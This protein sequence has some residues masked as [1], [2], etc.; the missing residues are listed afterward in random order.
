VSHELSVRI[1]L[2]GGAPA[3]LE[4][5]DLEGRRVRLQEVAGAGE[6]TAR[7]EG[8]DRVPA[9]VYVLRLAQGRDQR[10]ARVAIMH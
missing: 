10:F 4:L 5:L 6:R 7:F 2:P 8:L 9:G 1:A 3:R